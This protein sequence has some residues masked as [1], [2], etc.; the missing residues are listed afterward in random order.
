MSPARVKLHP[1]GRVVVR[2]LHTAA[3]PWVAI[4]SS[5]E[6]GVY[7]DVEAFSDDDVKDWELF[8][9]SDEDWASR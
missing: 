9:S 5:N 6:A 1:D 4:S 2:A 7:L 8:V 3:R